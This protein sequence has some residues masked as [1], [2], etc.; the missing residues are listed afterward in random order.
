VASF[1]VG[2]VAS[3]SPIAVADSGRPGTAAVGK[4]A[5]SAGAASSQASTLPAPGCVT[6]LLAED[7]PDVRNLVRHV[8]EADGYRVE[9]AGD[10]EE[11]LA[12]FNVCHPDLVVLDVMMPRL[13]G[14]EVLARLRALGGD[15]ARVPVLVLSARASEGDI[16]CGFGLGGSDYVTKPFMIG[17][18]RARVR[19]LLARA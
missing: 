11:T 14:F 16:V 7:D 5:P 1:P 8:L 10:G 2:S 15:A 9:V 17:E 19:S 6:V 4:R 13:T 3:A 12:S 18:L